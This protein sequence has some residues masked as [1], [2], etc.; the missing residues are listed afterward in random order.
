MRK[1]THLTHDQT[2]YGLRYAEFVVPLV[3]SVQ[4]LSE[5]INS[6]QQQVNELTAKLNEL[7]NSPKTQNI[8]I[9]GENASFSF[10][11]FPNPTNGFVTVDYKLNVDTQISVELFNMFGQRVK[12]IVPQQNQKEGTY[13]AQISVGDLSAGTYLVTATS[14][15]Q[16]ESKQLV[17]NN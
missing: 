2:P 13:S 15:N 6:L 12:L 5:Q 8:G 9:N 1:S 14:G 11:L 4:E 17:V 7:T 10:S 16:V 3:K